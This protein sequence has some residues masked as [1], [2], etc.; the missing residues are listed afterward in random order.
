MRRSGLALLLLTACADSA[1][2]DLPV[3]EAGRVLVY[4]PV[5]DGARGLVRGRA[6]ANTFPPGEVDFAAVRSFPSEVNTIVVPVQSDGSFDFNIVASGRE[7]LEIAASL[8]PDGDVRG[9]G[10]FVQ[11][12]PTPLP[13]GRQVCCR[14]PRSALGRCVLRSD[15]TGVYGLDV[16]GGER[17]SPLCPE[18]DIPLFSCE[19]DRACLIFERRHYPIDPSA[20][21]ITP[22]SADGLVTV[23]G[24]VLPDG[25]VLLENRGLS[26]LGEAA[27]VFR[28]SIIAEPD[29]SFAFA[30]LEAR[31][32][33]E[34]VV[35]VIDLNDFRTPT[36]SSFVP[37]AP[38]ES[39]D[40][41]E[42]WPVTDLNNGA[43]AILGIRLFVT[44]TDGRGVCPDNP[45]LEPAYCFG[46]GLSFDELRVIESSIDGTSV[47]LCPAIGPGDPPWETC[48]DPGNVQRLVLDQPQRGVDGDP[49]AAPQFI[50]MI[51]DLTGAS[52][53]TAGRETYFLGLQEY[54]Q[55]LPPRFRI[56]VVPMG[57]DLDPTPFLPPAEAADLIGGLGCLGDGSCVPAATSGSTDYFAAVRAAASQVRS[58][59][60]SEPTG[61][62]LLT[63]IANPGSLPDTE[64]EDNSF[65]QAL[66]QVQ[67]RPSDGFQGVPV[68]IAVLADTERPSSDG[69]TLGELLQS[70]AA[71]SGNPGRQGRVFESEGVDRPNTFDL[72]RLLR[73]ARGRASGGFLMLYELLPATLE[74]LD[75]V[76]KLGNLSLRVELTLPGQ[77]AVEDAY[78]GPVEFQRVEAN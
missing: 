59:V 22:P 30:D 63:A 12:P 58:E 7:V 25:L 43:G 4:F 69:Q 75:E 42:V 55:W 9:P 15:A 27:S 46:G 13:V 61:R 71:F 67:A 14:S 6:R 26:G 68:D 65:E 49:R 44:G 70:L 24:N 64:S 3:A 29:G 1:G 18:A 54:V 72:R 17:E 10:A 2:S 39:V 73:D 51:V 40:V 8:D 77:P 16:D 32:D 57:G 36:L 33:D 38:V 41:V 52:A 19:D 11:V 47:Q 31:G 53:Q 34:I 28:Q 76:G 66:A 35:E 21:Q 20:V 5:G 23:T 37:D 62:V 45:E 56:A 60:G 74:G 50:A 48:T 78:V